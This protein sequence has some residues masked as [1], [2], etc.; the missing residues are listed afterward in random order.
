MVVL[1]RTHVYVAI[2][3]QTHVL[4]GRPWQSRCSGPSAFCSELRLTHAFCLGTFHIPPSH[5]NT[6]CVFALN[7]KAQSVSAFVIFLPCV[8]IRKIGKVLPHT[9]EPKM[10]RITWFRHG[11]HEGFGLQFFLEI[12]ALGRHDSA[13]AVGPVR[14]ALHCV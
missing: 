5:A 7:E 14:F 1:C 11:F 3:S 4:I 13:D 6:P 9:A 2:L 8:L 10:I 12:F